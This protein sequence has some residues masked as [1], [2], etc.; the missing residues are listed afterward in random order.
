MLATDEDAVICDFAETYHVLDIG[1]LD[2][3]LAATLAAGLAPD[4]RIMR[5]LNGTELPTNTL[6]L[7]LAADNLAML[8][9]FQSED[10]LNNVNRPQS[11]LAALT[12]AGRPADPGGITFASPEE[13]EAYRAKLIGDQNDGD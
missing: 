5:K 12:G 3:Q 10:G 7:A 1:A 4:S 11:I 9:W 13:F 2:L 8:R 6:L